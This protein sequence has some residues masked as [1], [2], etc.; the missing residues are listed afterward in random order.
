MN[1]SLSYLLFF[2]LERPNTYKENKTPWQLALEKV[3]N[4]D[5]R[6]LIIPVDL[7]AMLENKLFFP[8]G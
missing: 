8:R 7:D 6:L 1:K 4:L 2:N 5:K 3:P